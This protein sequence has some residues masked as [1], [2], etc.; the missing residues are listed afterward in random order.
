MRLI[1]RSETT[2]TDKGE[3]LPL[4]QD[5]SPS[6]MI[7]SSP[8]PDRYSLVLLNRLEFLNDGLPLQDLSQDLEYFHYLLFHLISSR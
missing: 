4:I 5:S 8:C 7:S 2:L 1:E 6:Q 3:V